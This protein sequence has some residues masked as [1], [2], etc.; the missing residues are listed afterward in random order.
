MTRTDTTK[1][2]PGKYNFILY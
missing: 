2:E 1:K